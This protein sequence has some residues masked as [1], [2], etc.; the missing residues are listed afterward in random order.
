MN[1]QIFRGEITGVS[2]C[3]AGGLHLHCWIELPWPASQSIVDQALKTDTKNG[4]EKRPEFPLPER[5]CV[6]AIYE[7]YEID[8]HTKTHPAEAKTETL[9]GKWL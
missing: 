4:F 1:S 3:F 5:V 6:R 8:I 9:W 2:E 7:V